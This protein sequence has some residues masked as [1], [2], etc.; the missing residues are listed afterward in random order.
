V[1]VGDSAIM[2]TFRQTFLFLTKLAWDSRVT[3]P[4]IITGA[5]MVMDMR[6]QIEINVH[7]ERMIFQG[8]EDEAGEDNLNDSDSWLTTDS[9]FDDV[10]E[11]DIENDED[12]YD[13]NA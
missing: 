12:G 2:N 9:E 1:L 4:I 3:L 6:M 8:D 11:D 7:T 10:D 13:D 5:F